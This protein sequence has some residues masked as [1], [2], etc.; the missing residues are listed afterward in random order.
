M[1]R[2][3]PFLFVFLLL[4]GSAAIAET[5][6]DLWLRYAPLDE[7]NAASLPTSIYVMG[8]SETLAVASG[9]LATGLAA[10]SGHDV[11]VAGALDADGMIVL[12]T[13]ESLPAIPVPEGFLIRHAKL[14]GREVVLIAGSDDVNVLYGVFGYLRHLQSGQSLT[15]LDIVSRPKI[16]LRVLNHWDNLDGSVERGYAGNSLWDWHKLPEYRDPRYADYA[17]ANASIGINGTVLNNVNA[18]A[19]ILTPTYL[20]KVA[21]LADVF[22]PY[23]IRVYLSARFSAP[24]EI[25]GLETADPLEASVRKWWREKANQIYALIPDFGGFLVKAN[26]EGQP[27]PQDYGRNHADGANMLADAV[28]PHGGVVMWRAFVYSADNAEDRVKQAYSEFIPLD[29]QFRDNLLVQVK[30]GPLDFQPRE[31]FHPLFG[32]ARQTPLMMEFQVTK[33]YLGFESHL[34]FLGTLWEEVLRSE[35]HATDGDS[36]VARVV[37]GTL[38]GHTLTGIAGVANT[39]SD[40]NWSGSVFNQA[41]W[42]AFGRLA[43]DPDQSAEAIAREWLRQTFSLSDVAMQP[44]VDMMLGSREAVVD[45]MTPLGLAHLMATGH[46]Y[47]PGPWVD[48]LPRDDWNPTYY[49]RA[50]R[51]GIGFDRTESGSNAV[52]QYHAP[53]SERWVD[54]DEVPDELLLWFHR[55][56]WTHRL[57]S[58][59]TVWEELVYRY[60]RGVARVAT[61]RRLWETYEDLVDAARFEEI[62]AFLSIQE[63]EARWWRDACIAY[64][65]SVSG[66]P[67]PDGVTPPAASLSDFRQRRFPHLGDE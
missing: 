41:N 65:Q 52:A 55:V 27:G 22:R 59:R 67:L 28:A 64:F 66:L 62:R 32:G 61:M 54:P 5:G 29:G 48:D 57:E 25:G 38:D 9:E 7:R 6:Y 20:E 40:S 36:T 60:D 58:G 49:H 8:E 26:S 15:D 4:F 53:L 3:I 31:P 10:L 50:D 13:A 56:P 46:H 51:D 21:A 11:D 35:T 23:G 17:R 47:G 12:A 39:G 14:G 34:A 30:N 37:D 43:W 19:Q 63:R 33:E 42:Y 45:Y 2:R 16:G 1:T 24:V 18:N 44:L